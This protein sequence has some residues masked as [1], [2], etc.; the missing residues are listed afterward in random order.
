MGVP[1]GNG[2]SLVPF[3][4]RLRDLSFEWLQD[5]ELRR[6]IRAKPVTREEQHA[7]F[8]SLA[9]R[10]DYAI[11][12][13]ACDGVPIG[14]IGLKDI[15]V[16]DGAE[17]FMYIGEP[18]YATGRGM[19]NWI[20]STIYDLARQRGLKYLYGVVDR[21]NPRAL[22]VDTRFGLEIVREDDEVHYLAMKI[23]ENWSDEED[24]SPPA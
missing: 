5:P 11:W 21:D 10:T 12:G 8:A 24:P 9:D 20:L 19:A 4:E 7:W 1:E 16:D 23:V 6:L 18:S 22:A 3:D 15:G 14:A 2:L 13:V 17:G